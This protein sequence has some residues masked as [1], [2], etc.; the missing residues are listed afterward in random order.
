M[1]RP[2]TRPRWWTQV[3]ALGQPP[4][5]RP[6]F[7]LA[8]HRTGSTLLRAALDT[9]PG[10]SLAGEVLN[11]NNKPGIVEMSRGELLTYLDRSL[12]AERA[13][14]V[15]AKV[16]LTH[17]RPGVLP[18][19]ALVEAY[20]DARYV[21]LF[22]R[23]LLA[24]WISTRRAAES[25]AWTDVGTGSA[26]PTGRLPRAKPARLRKFAARQ[27]DRYAAALPALASADVELVAYEDLDADLPGTVAR[28]QERFG[29]GGAPAL[30]QVPLRRQRAGRPE[31]LLDNWEELRPLVEAGELTL[32]LDRDR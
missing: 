18:P 22:R 5:D 28:L 15:G 31:E 21:V 6:I 12:R 29:L 3:R 4:P 10:V 32:D 8:T 19:E 30:D 25:G 1:R 23:D 17:L 2:S 20:P 7:V 27:R 14:V 16:M 11:Q 26:E 9:L 13:P 24:Q